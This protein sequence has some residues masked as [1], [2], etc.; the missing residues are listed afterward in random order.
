MITNSIANLSSAHMYQLTS[1]MKGASLTTSTIILEHSTKDN[2]DKFAK[3]P[4]EL[5]KIEDSQDAEIARRIARMKNWEQSVVSH[6][7]THMQVGGEFA[8]S[9]SYIYQKGPDGKLY[10]V[11]GEVSMRLPAGGDLEKLKGALE[12]VKRAAMS[13]S[14]PSA[15]DQKTAALAA[16]QQISVDNAIKRKKALAAYE[17]QKAHDQNSIQNEIKHTVEPFRRLNFKEMSSFEMFA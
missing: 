13:P 4:S 17:K 6:E 11:G 3:N 15:Q 7:N 5:V 16:S 8:G 9:P 12:R 10:I 1:S 2:L 14:D